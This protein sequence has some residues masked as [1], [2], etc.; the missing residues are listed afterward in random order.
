VLS[1]VHAFAVAEHD[2]W[3]K[4]TPQS[5]LAT[6]SPDGRFTTTSRKHGGDGLSS[7]SERHD[8]VFL[9][10]SKCPSAQKEILAQDHAFC[11]TDWIGCSRGNGVLEHEVYGLHLRWMDATHL[12]ASWTELA[13]LDSAGHRTWARMTETLTVSMAASCDANAMKV[14]MMSVK[15]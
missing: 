12:E 14:E 4:P 6:R 2:A 5:A 11:E 10:P 13:G 3:P 15:P 7:H 9:A 8:C 1:G